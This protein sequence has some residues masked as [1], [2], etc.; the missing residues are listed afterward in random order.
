MGDREYWTLGFSPDD[1]SIEFSFRR[2]CS[3]LHGLRPTLI[4]FVK[5]LGGLKDP[6]SFVDEVIMKCI[7]ALSAQRCGK[8]TCMPYLPELYSSLEAWVKVRIGRPFAGTRSGMITNAIRR[9]RLAE[10]TF[11]GLEEASVHSV[12]QEVPTDYDEHMEMCLDRL[13][14]AM[15]TVSRRE[16]RKMFALRIHLG[17]H[18][19]PSLTP[20]R[21]YALAIQA[22]LPRRSCCQ[23]KV[24]A[25]KSVP[26]QHWGKRALNQEFSGLLIAVKPRQVR[27]IICDVMRKLKVELL[28]E[29]GRSEVT[30]FPANDPKAILKRAS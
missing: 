30:V 8:P 6:E 4:C 3:E 27:Y 26:A 22:G 25:E 11:V 2:A 1:K 10:R 7:G 9:Q 5:R 12:E 14:K 21:V 24:L 17:I 19:F 29:L 13:E 18:A 28:Q 16:P 15:N 20:E 23:I